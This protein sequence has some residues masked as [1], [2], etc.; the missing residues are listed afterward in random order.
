MAHLLELTLD[1]N[2]LIWYKILI[3]EEF[4]ILPSQMKEQFDYGCGLEVD[5]FLSYNQLLAH[6]MREIGSLPDY[7]QN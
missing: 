3:I 7:I 1:V 4:I 6:Y 5:H 2:V